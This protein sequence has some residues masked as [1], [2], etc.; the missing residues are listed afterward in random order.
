MTVS[1]RNALFFLLILGLCLLRFVHLNAD[2]PR[3]LGTKSAALYVDE[4]YKTL[5]AR[6]LAL[7][8]STHW[9]AEDT[10]Q[11]WSDRSPITQSAYYLAFKAFD[12]SVASARVVTIAFFCAL[13]LLFYFAHR[14]RTPDVYIAGGLAML[15]LS[16][17][18]FFFS[19]VALFEL[20]IA[21]FAYALVC[22]P[23]IAPKL[24]TGAL[25]L[26]SVGMVALVTFGIKSSGPIYLL[27]VI[28]G[29][30]LAEW[31]GRDVRVTP[32]QLGTLAAV[33][34]AA[35][36][37]M[38]AT[39]GVW[40]GRVDLNPVDWFLR[41]IDN[42]LWRSAWALSLLGLVC[43]ALGIGGMGRVF[44]KDPYRAALVCLVVLGPILLGAFTY[45]PLR[46][47]L[48]LCPAYVL[49]A[50]EWLRHRP[51]DRTVGGLSPA[52]QSS[53]VVVLMVLMIGKDVW[54]VGKFMVAPNYQAHE[55]RQV[56]RTQV[57]DDATIAGDWAPFFALDTS[58]RSLY[59]ARGIANSADSLAR[60]R[61]EYFLTTS[62]QTS[63]DI[64]KDL[65]ALGARL[66]PALFSR[67]YARQTVELRRIHWPAGQTPY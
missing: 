22:L 46:Y 52:T 14:K 27:P 30:L 42:P 43:A 41:Y 10:Y 53:V 5:D 65:E 58:L 2:S 47:Y 3:G 20:P 31:C 19:R 40:S 51:R 23:R 9:H 64:V 59:A 45:H 4:G 56:M 34:A 12:A 29:F 66:E 21:T 37:L 54:T 44:L 1:K 11:G 24:K 18:L 33:L 8:D 16:Y 49:L 28:A 63:E 6:N 36:T 61:P 35:V 13:L 38:F 57:P 15:G 62:T 67:E 26:V 7:F 39:R 55:I 25:M 60:I 32:R 17:P 48:P 50:L